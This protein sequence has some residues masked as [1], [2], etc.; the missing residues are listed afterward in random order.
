MKQSM[1]LM[2]QSM[3]FIYETVN[4]TAV[5]LDYVT[6]SGHEDKTSES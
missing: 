1:D 2:K 3:D 4:S 6:S 5:N